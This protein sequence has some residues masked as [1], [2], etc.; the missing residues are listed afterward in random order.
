MDTQRF[1]HPRDSGPSCG[2]GAV[3]RPGALTPSEAFSL[4]MASRY[5]PEPLM[6]GTCFAVIPVSNTQQKTPWNRT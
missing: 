1:A 3:K 4:G 5:H 2:L 6:L